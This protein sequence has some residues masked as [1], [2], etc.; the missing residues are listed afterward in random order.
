M[1]DAEKL[2][3]E[4][5]HKAMD[6]RTKCETA[7]GQTQKK[8]IDAVDR[9]ERGCRV[10]GLVASCG[11]TLTKLISKNDY[12]LKLAEKTTEPEKRKAELEQWLTKVQAHNDSILKKARDYLDQC[13]VTEANSQS[14]LGLRQAFNSQSSKAATQKQSSKAPKSAASKTSSQRRK[15]LLIAQR[16][17]EEIERQNE[18]SLLLARE[19]Q[20]MERKRL[21]REN[22]LEQA[23][24]E[25]EQKRIELE[26]KRQQEQLEREQKLQLL[27][28][29]EENRKKLV[30][31]SLA[32]LELFDDVSEASDLH[33]TL[34]RLSAASIGRETERVDEWVNHASVQ[35][36]ASVQHV[37]E[38]QE[39]PGFT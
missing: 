16:R 4:K 12:L 11:E 9:S 15:D 1:A 3:K 7:L 25:L 26:Q 29:E 8:I 35:P 21:E 6:S 22:E 33:E 14:S 2:L 38:V 13:P 20:E 17:R 24:I 10:E 32:E 39:A 36:D 37:D 19:A 30:E 28:L 27:R 34:S 18:A 5:L 23:R 31:A